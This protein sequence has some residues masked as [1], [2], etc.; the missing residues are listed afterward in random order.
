VKLVDNFLDMRACD[1]QGFGRSGTHEHEDLAHP[2]EDLDRYVV[3]QNGAQVR[4]FS[5]HQNFIWAVAFSPDGSYALTGSDDGTAILWDAQSGAKVRTFRGHK[6]RVDSVAFSSDG[7]F[8]LTGSDDATAIIWET[9][10]GEKVHQI[11][12]SRISIRPARR[13]AHVLST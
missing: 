6:G 8:A 9:Q 7:K 1:F 11:A 4:T 5:G 10:T 2:R 12:E 3:A 13:I